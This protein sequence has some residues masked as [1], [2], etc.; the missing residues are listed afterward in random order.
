MPFQPSSII[1]VVTHVQPLYAFQDQPS[2]GD[3]Y[4][5]DQQVTAPYADWYRKPQTSL[6]AAAVTGFYAAKLAVTN[7]LL[8]ADGS[9][10]EGLSATKQ[11]PATTT[12]S[13]SYTHGMT[14]TETSTW[15]IGGTASLS[16]GST[17][18]TATATG[19][20]SQTSTV[21]KNTQE[22]RSISDIDIQATGD[23][24]KTGWNL[25]FNNLVEGD[26]IASSTTEPPLSARST[27]YFYSNWLWRV[28]SASDNS[29]ESFILSTSLNGSEWH[30]KGGLNFASFIDSYNYR[31]A[32]KSYVPTIPEQKATILPPNRI[33]TGALVLNNAESSGT[34]LSNVQVWKSTN[35]SAM[36]DYVYSQES[37]PSGSSL[38]LWLPSGV[39][40][41][42]IRFTK[43]D[44]TTMES[45]RT[46][47]IGR[48]GSVTM[49]SNNADDFGERDHTLITN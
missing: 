17:G 36:P 30:I 28:S 37:I 14:L 9:Q 11:S 6:A 41:G 29:D 40:Y 39:D 31:G 4:V 25:I 35:S 20:Y 32:M 46:I 19:S 21:S 10:P 24:T 48:A 34:Y 5:I 26:I 13:T 1:S 42:R 27:Q 49:Y 47:N 45:Q 43:S 16:S 44:R 23:A 7:T 2:P 22:T 38:T 8:K 33:P 18:K 12:G 3:Y 15:S